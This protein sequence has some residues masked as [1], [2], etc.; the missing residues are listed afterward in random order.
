MRHADDSGDARRGRRDLASPRPRRQIYGKAA[1]R[2]MQLEEGIVADKTCCGGPY[3][4]DP[5][6]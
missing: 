1:R 4:L 5:F 3:A 6:C 2:S